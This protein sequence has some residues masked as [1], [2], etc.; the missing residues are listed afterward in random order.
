MTRLRTAALALL[1]ATAFVGCGDDNPTDPGPTLTL[2][3]VSGDGQVGALGV[4]LPAPFVV[5]V[6]DATGN[7]VSGQTVTWALA[8][9]AGPNSSL[10][11]TSTASGTDGR[12]SVTFTVGD[13][14]GTYEVRAS[15][16]GSSVTFS[17]EATEAGMECGPNANAPLI[18]LAPGESSLVSDSAVNCVRLPAHS[19]AAAYEV[20]LTPVP[21]VLAYNSITLQIEGAGTPSPASLQ[22]VDVA[23]HGSVKAAGAPDLTTGK[24]RLQYEWD[25]HLRDL[26]RPLLPSLRAQALRPSFGL[27]AIP[28]VGDERDFRFSCVD[29]DPTFSALPDTIRAKVV[30]V[31]EKAVIWEDVLSPDV[32]DAATYGEIAAT[33][34]TLIYATDTTYFGSP[35]DIDADGKISLLY[36]PAVNGITNELAGTYEQGFVAGFFCEAD[37]RTDTDAWNRAE[38]FYLVV[39]DPN[40]DYVDDGGPLEE[41]FVRLNTDN[42]IAHEFQHMINAQTGS[43]AADEVWINEGLSHLAEEVVGHRANGFLPGMELG[44]EELLAGPALENFFKYYL[45]NFTNLRIYLSAP[46]DTAALLNSVDPLDHE[47]GT[48]RMRGANWSFLRYLLDRFAAPGDEWQKT[49]Q[50][51]TDGAIT[52]SRQAVENVFGPE[53]ETLVAEWSGMFAV[54]D[55]DDLEGVPEPEFI[56]PS[57][58]LIDI[59]ES[60][61]SSGFSYPLSF[62]TSGIGVTRT[63]ATDLFT[64]TAKYVR[65]SA[66]GPSAA[67]SLRLETPDGGDLPRAWRT[68][69][70]IVRTK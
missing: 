2:T 52:N 43:G 59:Y 70:V 48:F 44:P 65:L 69:M 36:T 40:G 4:V 49:R 28:T 38:M 51:I 6:E 27:M 3:I 20:V 21:D 41:S 33:F 46:E 19:G 64:A 24:R 31:S 56:L 12:A 10:S 47:D 61:Q 11:A 22:S 66:A 55:R 8:S 5:Q 7:P 35:G 30:V 26:G 17:A 15:I 14:A 42:T 32:F 62:E 1:M 18:Q 50:L 53:F 39:P 57:Y 29:T 54:E 25:R 67:T 13:A 37:L 63:I 68:Q 60:S 45:G 34:D 23:Q 9:A 16:P 58:R